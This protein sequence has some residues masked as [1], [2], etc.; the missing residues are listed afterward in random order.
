VLKRRIKRRYL[1]TRF[2]N[3]RRMAVDILHMAEERFGDEV[4]RTCIAENVSLAESPA[5]HKT[6]FEHRPDSRGAQDY[7]A[8]LEELLRDGFIAGSA[9]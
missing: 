6:V 5:L 2:N 4:C 1:L 8:L 7:D 3:R 9:E